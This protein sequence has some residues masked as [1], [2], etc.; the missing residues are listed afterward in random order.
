MVDFLGLSRT[1]RSKM[2]SNKIVV[3]LWNGSNS[4]E[5]S[6]YGLDCKT[7]G[8]MIYKRPLNAPEKNLIQEVFFRSL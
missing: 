6:R 3:K 2:K 5:I 4:L 1:V 8:P 7:Y